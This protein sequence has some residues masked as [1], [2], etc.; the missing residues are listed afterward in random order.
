[1]GIMGEIR[2][3]V[4]IKNYV[5]L[6]CCGDIILINKNKTRTII[7]KNLIKFQKVLGWILI[8]KNF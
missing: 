6:N 8:L 1:M 4:K 3:L 2:N 7:K 5:F